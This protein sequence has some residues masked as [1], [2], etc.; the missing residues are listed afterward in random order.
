MSLRAPKYYQP[1]SGSA[2]EATATL[3][4]VDA[5]GVDSRTS[6]LIKIMS[7]STIELML[8]SGLISD[9]NGCKWHFLI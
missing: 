4:A 6:G 9:M 5:C 3:E 1:Q 8:I 7:L 2:F